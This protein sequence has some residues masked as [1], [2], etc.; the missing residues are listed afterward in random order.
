MAADL[1]DLLAGQISG[2]DAAAAR[3][4]VLTAIFLLLWW[5]WRER[6]G[7]IGFYVMFA[8]M[9]TVSVQLVGV[10]LV[11]SSLIIPA[12]AVYRYPPRRRLLL[13]FALSLA[14]YASGLALSALLDLPS[15]RH[16]VGDG[17]ARV[18][19]HLGGRS[20]ARQHRRLTILR[21]VV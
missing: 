1:K 19:V 2:V 7:R 10:Y 14:S 9:V 4:G 13:G 16:R 11:F 8:M 12:L 5:K 6:L 20:R 17:A 18:G 15:A 21:R 3:A